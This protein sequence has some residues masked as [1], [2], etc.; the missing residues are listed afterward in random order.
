MGADKRKMAA[1]KV[2]QN[3]PV[4]LK[5]NSGA[6]HLEVMLLEVVHPLIIAPP[7]APPNTLYMSHSLYSIL[8]TNVVWPLF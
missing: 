4:K 5:E 3:L 8:I 6:S 7:K 1:L 2:R